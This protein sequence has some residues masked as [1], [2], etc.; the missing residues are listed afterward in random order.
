MID[1]VHGIGHYCGRMGDGFWGEPQNSLSNAAFFVA[2]GLGF[3]AWRDT[4]KRDV[5]QLILIALT[6]L[7][8]VGSFV[9]H[10][11]PNDLTLQIDLIPIQIFG[12]AAL[13]FLAQA[14]FGL[15]RWQ[16]V[17]AVAVFFALRQ[18]WLLFVPRG[19]LGGGISH[20]P[21]VVLL[22]GSGIWLHTHHRSVGRY[23]LVAAAFYIA[24]LA[25]RSID[26]PLCSRFPFG[27]HWLWHCL[28]AS[29]TGAVLLGLIR[30]A[31]AGIDHPG[32][33]RMSP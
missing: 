14:E 4:G 17:L 22:I 32:K 15:L 33:C 13:L 5:R 29:V 18:T 9:F 24:A 11:I 1:T 27:F 10:S 31:P 16:A 2:A 30:A 8:G 19:A 23:L 28:T 20:V 6:A 7:I 12:L 25:V 3:L 26:L 21:M